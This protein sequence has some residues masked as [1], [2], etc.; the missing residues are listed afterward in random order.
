MIEYIIAFLNIFLIYLV[1]SLST[2]ALLG[3]GG[4]FSLFQADPLE[5]LIFNASVAIFVTL[6]MRRVFSVPFGISVKGY[7]EDEILLASYGISPKVIK[8]KLFT[9]SGATAGTAGVLYASYTSFIDP[10]SFTLM[11]SVFIVSTV[12]LG[13]PGSVMGSVLGTLILLGIPEILR[14]FPNMGDYIFF[15]RQ[16]LLSTLIIL[17]LYFRPKGLV[18]DYAPR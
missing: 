13:G 4:I 9:F 14:Y 15:L 12:L 1:L 7:R 16:I 18:G 17:I 5:Y 3:F 8:L 11:E 2:N 10:T 6:F